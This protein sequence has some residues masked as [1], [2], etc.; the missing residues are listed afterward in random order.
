MLLPLLLSEAVLWQAPHKTAGGASDDQIVV[1]GDRVC[2]LVQQLN[3]AGS[4]RLVSTT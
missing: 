3:P 2:T 4:R 1:T